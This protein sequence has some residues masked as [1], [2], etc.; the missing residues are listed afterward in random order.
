MRLESKCLFAGAILTL[1]WLFICPKFIL[2]GDHQTR[3][4]Y[5]LP[6]IAVRSVGPNRYNE[7]IEWEYRSSDDEPIMTDLYYDSEWRDHFRSWPLGW[8]KNRFVEE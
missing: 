3:S 1:L 5:K 7:T 2:T 8:R 4:S 6:G